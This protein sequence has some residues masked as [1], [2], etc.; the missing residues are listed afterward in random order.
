LATWGVGNMKESHCSLFADAINE[1]DLFVLA[2]DDMQDNIVDDLS[3]AWP[4]CPT[5]R[6]GLHPQVRDETPI[7]WCH[8]GDGHAVAKIG[9]LTAGFNTD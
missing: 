2:A 9:S 6:F 7:W 8:Y 4:S 5:H 1:L 3:K